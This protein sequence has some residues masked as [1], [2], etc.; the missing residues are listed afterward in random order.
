MSAHVTRQVGL[1]HHAQRILD[2]EQHQRCP[3]VPQEPCAGVEYLIGAAGFL[4][5]ILRVLAQRMMQTV[6]FMGTVVAPM[7][8]GLGIHQTQLRVPVDVAF[9]PPTIE[10]GQV[11][12]AGGGQGGV[13]P[14]EDRAK[15]RPII[16]FKQQNAHAQNG[17]FAELFT[18]AIRHRAQVFAQHNGAMT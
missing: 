16:L 18:Q 11:V 15:A 12:G 17:A 10:R 4:L 1:L 6:A 2:G 8:F 13:G 9:Q 5:K 14:F 7:V 3:G